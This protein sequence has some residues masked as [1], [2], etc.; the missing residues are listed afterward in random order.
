MRFFGV[1]NF[2]RSQVSLLS[3]YTDLVNHQLEISLNQ[4][5]PIQNGLLDQCINKKITPTAW[6]P[7]GGG[8]FFDKSSSP[9]KERVI[10]MCKSL[11]EKYSCTL[12]QLLLA[13]L[14]KHPARIIPVMG[15]TKVLR[16]AT[17]LESYSVELSHEDWYKLYE[18]Q[19]GQEVA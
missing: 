6:S 13:F 12:D 17:A 8:V 16:L 14:T 3:R 7:L 10:S 11:Q 4:L 19:T 1:S 2:T 18:A 9:S 5:S 15:T